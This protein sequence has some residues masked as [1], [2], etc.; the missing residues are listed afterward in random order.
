MSK[1]SVKKKSPQSQTKEQKERLLIELTKVPIVQVACQ[2]V[3]V[4]RATYYSWRESD[5]EF[6]VLS[7][8][9]ISEGNFVINDLAESKLISNIQDGNNTSIIF[10][11][12]N[13]HSGY[14][15]RIIH[16]HEHSMDVSEEEYEKI[17]KALFNIGYA[18]TLKLNE[19]DAKKIINDYRI[20][21]PDKD[22]EVRQQRLKELGLTST[23]SEAGT[24]HE[25][26]LVDITNFM[27]KYKKKH[28]T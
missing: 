5:T 13:H 19:E 1:T 9:A 6:K 26:S 21:H 28:S 27:K 3:G 7:D 17:S 12:K 18:N 11:L 10:W 8:K 14:N 15:D 25:D 24:M 20:A 22:E 2:R 23:N 16:E 4:G